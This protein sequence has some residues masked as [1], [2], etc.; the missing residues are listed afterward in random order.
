[1]DICVC[2]LEGDLKCLPAPFGKFTYCSLV[3]MKC[4]LVGSG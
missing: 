3:D 1:M 4:L 2:F